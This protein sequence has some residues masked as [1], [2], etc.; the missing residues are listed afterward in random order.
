MAYLRKKRMKRKKSTTKNS[1]ACF[2]CCQVS[3][4]IGKCWKRNPYLL[5]AW[6][7][8]ELFIILNFSLWWVSFYPVLS[9][10][11][12]VE[13]DLQ[14]YFQSA[15]TNGE[16]KYI[17]MARYAS[18]KK[19][20]QLLLSILFVLTATHSLALMQ[21]VPGF[22]SRVMAITRTFFDKNVIPFYG[23]LV[24]LLLTFA[25]GLHFAFGVDNAEYRQTNVSLEK[26]FYVMF[27]D[28]DIG[29]DDMQRSSIALAYTVLLILSLAL[30]L[31]MMNIFIAV[32]SKVY[33]DSYDDAKKVF[34]SDVVDKEFFA[35]RSQYLKS[36]VRDNYLAD[37]RQITMKSLK[38]CAKEHHLKTQ[39]SGPKTMQRLLSQMQLQFYSS[40][41]DLESTVEKRLEAVEKTLDNTNKKKR[42]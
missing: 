29:F 22:G 35:W 41:K 34:E 6:N 30:T 1:S 42:G 7:W 25:L 15:M 20:S 4:V 14:T 10:R 27:G 40:M 17:D 11:K 2:S 28:L 5:N 37:V 13:G 18:A 9:A 8:F 31:V 23:F 21:R 33:E 24:C 32:V 38:H 19:T 3:Y 36:W 39:E 12:E 26:V 16:H